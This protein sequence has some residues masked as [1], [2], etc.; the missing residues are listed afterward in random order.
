MR[1][2]TR[3][4]RRNLSEA[5]RGLPAADKPIEAPAEAPRPEHF[6]SPRPPRKPHDATTWVENIPST[7]GLSAPLTVIH[8]I[9]PRSAESLATLG[10][11]TLGDML[12]NFPRRYDDYSQLKPIRDVF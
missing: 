12:Y 2:P 11:N 5:K 9:G 7:Q 10:L 1:S 6:S 8:G 3:P 4:I